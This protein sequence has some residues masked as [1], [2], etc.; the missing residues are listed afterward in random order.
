MYNCENCNNKTDSIIEVNA[1]NYPKRSKS[2]KDDKICVCQ[3]CKNCFEDSEKS[4]QEILSSEY[5]N[6]LILG[7]PGTGKT[8]LFKN[9]IESLPENSNILVIT[10]IN[11]LVDDLEKRLSEI[12]NRKVEV[13]T[14]HGF[15]KNFLLNKIH[16]YEYFPELPRIIEDDASLLGL[17]FRERKFTQA[18]VNLEKEN[19]GVKFYLSRS[20][21]Y[22]SVGHDDTVYRIFLHLNENNGA[23]PQYSQVIVDEYQDF[24]LFESRLIELISQKNKIMIAGDDDQA[25]YRF[26]FA[27]PDF[28]RQLYKDKQFKSLF[29]PFCRRCTSV[30][31]KA[32]SA[33]I[34]N[35]KEKGLLNKRIEK[36]FKCYW[37]DK[38]LDSKKYPKIFLGKCSADSVVSKH[39]NEKILSIIQ[40]EKTQPS[41]KDEPEFLIVGPPRISHYLREV[42]ES[43]LKDKRIDKDIFEIEFKKESKKLSI[44]EGYE[45]IKKDSNSNLGWRIVIY[46]DRIDSS[47]KK[48]REIIRE[49]LNGKSIIDLLPA[50]YIN[51]HK[52]KIESISFQETENS[53]DS[54]DKKIK[55]KLTTYLG[56]KGLS[57]N[58]VFVLGLENGIFPKDSKD[59]SD[60][61]ACQFIV[62]LTRARR[63][64]RIL[65]VDKRFNKKIK[66][67]ADNLSTFVSMIPKDFLEIIDINASNFDKV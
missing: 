51:K 49:S 9:I 15:C 39:I 41:E 40:D 44:N 45:F 57:A 3:Q 65:S 48:D 23:I 64:L 24:N 42:N 20:A 17:D 26:K 30:L 6:K 52:E 16:P 35:A 37:P 67:R 10:F 63:S 4:L 7:G 29:L 43:L 53:E 54:L 61:E 11:N 38:F 36:E 56:A 60:D 58:H 55:I 18:F 1:K 34:L 62:L 12:S 32:A 22:N 46:K 27:S 31:V 21:F 5:K 28:I 8:F 13:R 2:E 66:Q 47:L 59:I 14:L 19:D 25:L 50:E 33:F